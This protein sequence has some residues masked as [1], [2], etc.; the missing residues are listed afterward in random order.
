MIFIRQQ[1]IG[2]QGPGLQ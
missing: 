1:L 2:L